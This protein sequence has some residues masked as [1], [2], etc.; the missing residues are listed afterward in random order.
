MNGIINFH[1]PRGMTSHDAVYYFRRLLNIKKIGHS[2][3]LDPNVEGVLPIC[4][5]KGTRIAEYLLE[6]DKEYIGEL[7]LTYSTDT[8]DSYGKLIDQSSK[9]VT[10]EDIVH[11][12]NK[13]RGDIKQIPPMYSA[14]KFKGKKLYDLAREG[15]TVERQ[16]RNVKIYELDIIN[17]KNNLNISFYSKCSK[18]TYIRTLCNDIA[19]DLGMYGHL[20]KL[21]R[22]GVGNF[23]IKDSR[24]MDYLNSINKKELEEIIIPM[25][26]AL[27]DF[28]KLVIEDKE[29]KKIINGVTIPI[30]MKLNT[31][32]LYR[33]YCKNKFI[34][35]GEIVLS[36]DMKYLKMK[37]VFL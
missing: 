22:T 34:G 36:G 26:V 14:L 18:G 29:Y 13:F 12:F 7:D 1:K 28:V 31:E 21:I 17:N 15:K 6:A 2:G 25:D 3:T 33:I 16:A 30:D 19:T 20:S 9:I 32:S 27:N 37:K 5:G 23:N 11:S 24:T 4:I 35:I 8:Q 10:K